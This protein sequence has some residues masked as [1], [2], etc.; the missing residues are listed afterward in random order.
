MSSRIARLWQPGNPQIR[1]FL[2]DFWMRFN[3]TYDVGYQRL[4]QN[5][6]EFEVDP[7][8]TK[9][10]I[11][12]YLEKI[13]NL[14]VREVRTRNVMGKMKYDNPFSHRYRR[15]Y[16]KEPDQK[17]AIVF[18]KKGTVIEHEVFEDPKVINSLKKQFATMEKQADAQTHNE[19]F[20]NRNRGRVGRLLD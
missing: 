17:Y 6:A 13:Y 9:F 3:E 2:P 15:A 20:A 1:C 19:K 18:F 4:P 14:P 7:Q 16:F 8:M 5:A 10:D 12:Q 11:R